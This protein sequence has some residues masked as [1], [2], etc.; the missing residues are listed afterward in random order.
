MLCDS[1]E[2]WGAVGGRR[3]VQE[4]TYVYLSLIHVEVWQKLTQH[5]KAIILQLK[6]NI[7][8]KKRSSLAQISEY[9]SA[10]LPSKYLKF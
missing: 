2:G 1:V 5:C 3:E 6:I 8:F 10:V 9:Y 4:E 7:F